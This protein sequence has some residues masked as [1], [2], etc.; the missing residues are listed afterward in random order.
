MNEDACASA[1][2]PL[3]LSNIQ[4][5]ELYPEAVAAYTLMTYKGSVARVVFGPFVD[6]F[7]RVAGDGGGNRARRAWP[8]ECRLSSGVGY[9]GVGL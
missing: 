9:G 3:A 5:A 2:D 1:R 8:L 6:V 7:D 4:A